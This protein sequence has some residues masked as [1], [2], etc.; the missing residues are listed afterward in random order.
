MSYFL[1]FPLSYERKR[2]LAVRIEAEEKKCKRRGN[3]RNLGCQICFLSSSFAVAW[4][5]C[6]R[7]LCPTFRAIA[8]WIYSANI[9]AFL[10]NSKFKTKYYITHGKRRRYIRPI[11]SLPRS[12]PQFPSPSDIGANFLFGLEGL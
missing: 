4:F 11:S 1:L 8:L 10:P 5:S 12:S 7:L 3:M 2:K 6:S 9:S